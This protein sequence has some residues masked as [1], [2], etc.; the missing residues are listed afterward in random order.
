MPTL[1]F[2]IYTL[3]SGAQQGI[4]AWLFRENVPEKRLDWI[5]AALHFGGGLLYALFVLVV[6]HGWGGLSWSAWPLAGWAL[7]TR[8]L[9][10]DVV[11]NL[12]RQYFD[13]REGRGS[14]FGIS[15]A[16]WAVGTAALSDRLTN[17]VA[18]RAGLFPPVLRFGSWAVAVVGAVLLFVLKR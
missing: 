1:L 6:I 7:L 4:I 14:F 8:W 11:L 10:F 15:F 13:Y 18:A 5:N 16:P 3:L 9:L 2:I 12:T 17:W